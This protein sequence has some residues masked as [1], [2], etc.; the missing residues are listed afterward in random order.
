MGPGWLFFFLKTLHFLFCG[1]LLAQLVE[2]GNVGIHVVDVVSI[3]WV[4][5]NVPLIWLRALCGEHV[6]AVLGF[7]IHTV[8]TCDLWA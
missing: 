4:L 3:R 2:N 6:T 5:Y 7:V 8:K 1:H